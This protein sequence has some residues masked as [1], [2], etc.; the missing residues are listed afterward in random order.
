[1]PYLTVWD[2]TSQNLAHLEANSH[3]NFQTI[4]KHIL[5]RNKHKSHFG[6]F[7]TRFLHLNKGFLTILWK[8]KSD[9][10]KNLT[11]FDKISL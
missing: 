9:F 8:L 4:L 7:I 6:V 3:K 1:M 11:E 5:W 10:C 2:T